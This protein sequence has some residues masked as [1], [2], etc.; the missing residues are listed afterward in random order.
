[1]TAGNRATEVR[2]NITELSS[3]HTLPPLPYGYQALEPYIDARTMGLHHDHHHAPMWQPSM[4]RSKLFRS[5]KIAAH[6]GC[7]SI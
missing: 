2:Q 3:K 7:Y 4:Q 5:C 6:C 1:M